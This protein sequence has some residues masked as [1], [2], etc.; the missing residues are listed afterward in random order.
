MVLPVGILHDDLGQVLQ[1]SSSPTTIARVPCAL[2]QDEAVP[3]TFPATLSRE[4]AHA[5]AVSR[6]FLTTFS[7]ERAFFSSLV[8]SWSNRV[9]L[10]LEN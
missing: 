10:I 7:R 4:R 5:E 9:L 3:R 8:P 6:A 1:P 2:L